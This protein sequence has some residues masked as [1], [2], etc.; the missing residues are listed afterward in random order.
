MYID[1]PHKGENV[2]NVHN[3]QQ[4]DT[5]EDMGKNVPRIYVTLD[6]KQV[7]FHSHMISYTPYPPINMMLY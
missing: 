5:L 6:N 3:V 7:E 1:F 4:V 2:R